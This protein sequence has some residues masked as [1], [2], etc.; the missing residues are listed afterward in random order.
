MDFQAS[1]SRA[2]DEVK[3]GIMF[4]F[5]GLS[6]S[7]TP[8]EGIQVF[9]QRTHDAIIKSLL[10]QNDVMSSFWRNND[11]IIVPCARWVFIYFY[12]FDVHLYF[13]VLQYH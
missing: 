8:Q 6:A 2:V 7:S 1:I 5:D 12:Y 3:Q 13:M 10:R 9:P 4:V 11:F